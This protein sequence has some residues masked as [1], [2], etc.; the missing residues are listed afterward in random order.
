MAEN[1]EKPKIKEQIFEDYRKTVENGADIFTESTKKLNS[2]IESSMS[3]VEKTLG[4]LGDG[5]LEKNKKLS[6]AYDE[7]KK[8]FE[9]FQDIDGKDTVV[10][11]PNGQY[12]AV[13]AQTVKFD[14]NNAATSL[15]F[16]F[17]TFKLSTTINSLAATFA[18]NAERRAKL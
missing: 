3:S 4:K 14:F 18:D 17:S 10:A 8:V 16:G 9:G 7:Y 13:V 2:K 6:K 1:R 11:I 15:V 5:V 12:G